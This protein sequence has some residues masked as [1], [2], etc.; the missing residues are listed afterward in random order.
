MIS[1]VPGIV[2]FGYNQVHLQNLFINN[3]SIQSVI[4]SDDSNSVIAT[5]MSIYTAAAVDKIINES[6][7]DTLQSYTTNE[8]LTN[9]LTDYALKTEITE[10]DL[11]GY[12]KVDDLIV[13]D[14]AQSLT[15][16]SIDSYSDLTIAAFENITTASVEYSDEIYNEGITFI[17]TFILVADE[18][19]RYDFEITPKNSIT[20]YGVLKVIASPIE[21]NPAAG[22]FV[23]DKT[24]VV[25]G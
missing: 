16:G 21:V 11:S 12:R 20:L 7:T 23:W 6:L 24:M 10:V 15:I 8:S 13:V 22:N 5:D 18:S 14:A 9:T 1:I 25:Y 2:D 17:G 4:K 19:I 3:R